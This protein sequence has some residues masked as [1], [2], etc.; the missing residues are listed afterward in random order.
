MGGEV[1]FDFVDQVRDGVK[2]SAAQGLLCELLA[3]LLLVTSQARS[4][5]TTSPPILVLLTLTVRG[6]LAWVLVE[7]KSQ[8]PLLDLQLMRGN[9]MWTTSVSAALLGV[10]LYGL[11]TFLPQFVQTTPATG[12]GLGLTVLQSGLVLL[13]MATA[14][15]AM[16]FASARLVH[17]FGT[18]IVMVTGPALATLGLVFL[19][20]TPVHLWQAL[21]ASTLSGV[22]VGLTLA[23]MPALVVASVPQHQSGIAGGMNANIRTVGGALGAALIASVVSAVPG[24]L[25]TA[26]SYQTGFIVAAVAAALAIIIGMLT[27]KPGT[28]G[29]QNQSNAGSSVRRPDQSRPEA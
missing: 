8:G 2:R 13:P 16:R 18:R 17:R 21:T 11:Q 26:G 29:I 19:L 1:L 5:G 27:R 28:Q 9:T 10:V 4:W 14:I 7:R 12:Y 3:S 22:G 6:V 15:F 23:A 20:V 24:E 25:P